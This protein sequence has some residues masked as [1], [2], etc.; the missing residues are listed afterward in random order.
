MPSWFPDL[1]ESNTKLVEHK[2][3]LDE[4]DPKLE[5]HRDH[6][7]LVETEPDWSTRL[8]NLWNPTKRPTTAPSS[9]EEKLLGNAPLRTEERPCPLKLRLARC[10]LQFC[11]TFS[12]LRNIGLILGVDE[13]NCCGRGPNTC[14]KMGTQ[15]SEFDHNLFPTLILAL[16]RSGQV[17]QT[18]SRSRQLHVQRQRQKHKLSQSCKPRLHTPGWILE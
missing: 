5:S 9:V 4:R 15:A 16:G 17:G 13:C 3:K 10:A 2:P 8:P 7:N 12:P 6:V 11:S 14:S 18:G 1:V